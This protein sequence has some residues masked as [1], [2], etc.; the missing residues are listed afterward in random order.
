MG[1]LKAESFKDV[2]NNWPHTDTTMALLKGGGCSK[3]CKCLSCA[4]KI[5]RNA[6]SKTC[7][8]GNACPAGLPID[9]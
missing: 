1:R 7:H 2:Y 5:N 4:C 6:C 8:G 3:N 9:D